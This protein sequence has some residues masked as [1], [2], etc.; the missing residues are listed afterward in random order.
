TPC[1]EPQSYS[2]LS[3][4]HRLLKRVQMRGGAV[5]AIEADGPFSA[6]DAV[7]LCRVIPRDLPLHPLRQP[8]Q[9]LLER[10]VRVRPDAVGLRIVGTPDDVVLADERDDRL[11]V[12]VLLVRHVAL[13]TEVVAGLQREAERPRAVLVLGV[14]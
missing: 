9:V 14:E 3:A 11:Q 12:L 4:S 2:V 7:K 13:A 8:A 10:A 1:R 6:A 5:G